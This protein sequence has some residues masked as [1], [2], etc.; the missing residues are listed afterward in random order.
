[1][2]P[3][4]TQIFCRYQVPSAT[5]RLKFFRYSEPRGTRN[6]KGSSQYH[7]PNADKTK[8][9]LKNILASITGFKITIQNSLFMKEKNGKASFEVLIDAKF[10]S[11][12]QMGKL[13]EQIL[14]FRGNCL[15]FAAKSRKS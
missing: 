14:E 13:A 6:L 8:K 1:M 9:I 10:K 11:V 7:I 2:V 4:D 12:V 15:I 3:T 5:Q